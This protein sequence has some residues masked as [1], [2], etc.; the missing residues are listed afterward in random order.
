[1]ESTKSRTPNKNRILCCAIVSCSDEAHLP[2]EREKGG[3]DGERERRK[4][5][6]S[7]EITIAIENANKAHFM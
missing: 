4:K 7:D 5:L 2:L 3:G 1:M 6:N